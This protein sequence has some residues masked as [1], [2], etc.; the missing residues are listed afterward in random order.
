[1]QESRSLFR[2]SKD[3]P[4][5]PAQKDSS[6]L[7]MPV[8]SAGNVTQLSADLLVHTLALQRAGVFDPAYHVSVV[9]GPDGPAAAGVTVPMELFGSPG[10]DIYVLQQRSP[11]LKDHKEEFVQRLLEMIESSGFGALLYLVGSDLSTRTDAQMSSIYYHALSK[12]TTKGDISAA[13][14]GSI[15]DLPAFAD[16]VDAQDVV[17]PGAGLARRLLS[18]PGSSPPRV[19]LVQFVAEGDNVPDARAM[20]AMVAKLLKVEIQEAPSRVDD[21]ALPTPPPSP[22]LPI[23]RRRKT[24]QV[25]EALELDSEFQSLNLQD[26]TPPKDSQKR[27]AIIQRLC[28]FLRPE[29]DSACR[30]EVFATLFRRVIARSPSLFVRARTWESQNHIYGPRSISGSAVDREYQTNE[31]VSFISSDALTTGELERLTKKLPFVRGESI[32]AELIRSA[33][34]D[35]FRPRELRGETNY[36]ETSEKCIPLLGGWVYEKPWSGSVP[37]DAWDMMHQLV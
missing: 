16:S 26:E 10:G 29:S 20:A 30:A 25:N 34:A 12:N 23:P 27:N 15:L 37:L 36:T 35:V 17:I 21:R 9:G 24:K 33:I 11:V 14:L 5:L 19:A 2:L 8:I 13:P 32:S 7:I 18:A 3:G 6:I 28:V 4:G 22:T 1:M 31:V